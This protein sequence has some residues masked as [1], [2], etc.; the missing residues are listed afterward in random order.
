MRRVASSIRLTKRRA[1]APEP[2]IQVDL[3]QERPSR[4]HLKPQLRHASSTEVSEALDRTGSLDRA[5]K[6]SPEPR[7]LLQVQP[8]KVSLSKLSLDPQTYPAK[9]SR[10]EPQDTNSSPDPG[11]G[12]PDSKEPKKYRL[13]LSIIKVHALKHRPTPVARATREAD[14]HWHPPLGDCAS[15]PSIQAGS[16][17]SSLPFSHNPYDCYFGNGSGEAVRGQPK[18]SETQFTKSILK[19]K[20]SPQISLESSWARGLSRKKGGFVENLSKL[21]PENRSKR[22]KFAPNMTV[23]L[24]ET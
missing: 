23:Q 19:K 11:A 17:S 22:V 10:L 24:F 8:R 6:S 16:H 7:L 3:S 4:A 2:A 18:S 5:P 12:W 1:S 13:E 21:F 9:P 14:F 20:T 15:T